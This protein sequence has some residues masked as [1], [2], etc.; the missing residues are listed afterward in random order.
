MNQTPL[1]TIGHSNRTIEEFLGLLAQNQI[2][3]VADVRSQ[4][5]SSRCPQFNSEQLAATLKAAGIRYVF[6]GE[7]LGA[8]R[9]EPECY[10][11]GRARYD[12]IAKTTAFRKGLDRVRGGMRSYRMALL[13]T[14]KDPVTCHRTI[15]VCRYLRDECEIRHIVDTL[16]VES[17]SQAE[18]RLLRMVGLPSQ[19]LFQSANELID[20]AYE[21]Q[22]WRIAFRRSDFAESTLQE[23]PTTSLIRTFTIG[24]TKKSAEGFFT[25]LRDAGVVRVVDVRLGNSSQLAGFAKRD[26]LEF[27]LKGLYGIGY[28]HLPELAPTKE[29]L[30]AY[31]KHKGDWSV[32]EREFLE[33][34][35]RRRIQETIPKELIDQGCLLCSEHLPNHCHRRLVVEYL[36]R[37]WGP[38]KTTHLT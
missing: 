16:E 12:L 5:Y 31:K 37:Y 11:E 33:L 10:R 30:D 38:L 18:G 14:E 1:F 26:D 13:C 36:D 6:L 8:R 24:F 28:V 21:M 9:S 4:P 22:G 27:L 23:E 19:D 25:K 3:A 34:M 29:I 17:Q 35:D 15:L 2:D 20:Q 7:E 32:Y